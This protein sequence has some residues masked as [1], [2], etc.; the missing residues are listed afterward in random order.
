MANVQLTGFLRPLT[1]TCSVRIASNPATWLALIS[2]I[3]SAAIYRTRVLEVKDSNPHSAVN[4]ANFLVPFAITF[5]FGYGY[6]RME[7]QF[8]ALTPTNGRVY[9]L[10]LMCKSYLPN[11]SDIE[12]CWRCINIMHVAGACSVSLRRTRLVIRS[13]AMIL[14]SQRK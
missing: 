4:A 8:W 10:L 12:F 13:I 5:Y 11:R 7:R 14:M 9:D 3:T 6:S 1:T 2:F